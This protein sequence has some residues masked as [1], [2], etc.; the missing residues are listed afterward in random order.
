MPEG[1]EAGRKGPDQHSPS[2]FNLR[3]QLRR[4]GT[5]PWCAVVIEPERVAL[6]RFGA[7][8]DG[9]PRLAAF[10]E[11]SFRGSSSD[12]LAALRREHRLDRSRCVALLPGGEYQCSVV[13]APAVPADELKTA[14][15]WRLK[16]VIDYPP[17][18]A[19]V[20]VLPLPNGG[21]AG[22]PAQVLAVS[23]RRTRL[24]ECI[25]EFDAAKIDLVAIDIQET[26]Q[27]NVSALLE[28]GDRAQAFLVFN[29]NGMLTVTAG[30]EL[31]LART[32]DIGVGQLTGPDR[33]VHFDR[34]VLEVQRSL[35]HFD[36]QF[37]G[38]PLSRLVL[39]PFAAVDDL[40]STLAENLYVPV[41]VAEL[42][43]ALDL[44]AFPALADPAV[45]G[46]NLRLLGAALRTG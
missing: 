40:R 3:F 19:G 14:V 37:G 22:R 13:E 46:R 42:G 9:R 34:V 12:T 7:G 20:D 5:H 24:A 6:A 23:A 18:E 11:R 44:S 1:R 10:D 17:E 15:R 16:D 4:N 28:E 27:R 26:A 32:I 8:P 21:V 31:H 30:G 39:A 41:A 36:R 33:A 29:G 45:Q 35:D 38:R 25:R 2:D 43:R